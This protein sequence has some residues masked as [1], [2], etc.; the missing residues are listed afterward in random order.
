MR[1]IILILFIPFIGTAQILDR[2]LTKEQAQVFIKNNF[3]YNDLKY[4]KFTIDSTSINDTDVFKVGDFNH[5]GVKDFFISGEAKI[6][7]DVGKI[8]YTEKM[9][10]LG[11][12]KT[13]KKV[14][15]PS[16]FFSQPFIVIDASSKLI[17][18]NEKDYIQIKGNI[19]DEKNKIKESFSDIFFVKN[20]HLMPYAEK[21]SPNEITRI[22]FKTS[23]CFGSCPVY[24]LD[25]SKNGEATYNGIDF[26]DKKGEYKL[27]IDKKD[28][29][30]LESF[31]KSIDL[32]KL[33]DEYEVNWTD[34]QTS[35]L[36]VYSNNGTK[37]SIKDYGMV[38]TLKLSILYAYFSEL[39]KF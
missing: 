26:V 19:Y 3:R 24:E 16:E 15:F 12:K 13:A 18:K 36:T 21:A 2:I 22:E 38:G 30:Y 11:G 34:D 7:T 10:I 23:G 9:I 32:E 6:I 39:R 27:Q 5:D 20:D 1:Y 29:N 25:I 33:K 35:Y 28:W 4:D 17:S 8:G 37:K 31:V 14:T